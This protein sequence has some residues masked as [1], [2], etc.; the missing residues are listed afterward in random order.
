M[1]VS[2]N[3]FLIRFLIS[4]K[5]HAAKKSQLISGR[6]YR[7]RL[8]FPNGESSIVKPPPKY[9]KMENLCGGRSHK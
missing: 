7:N 1:Y 5:I 3:S 4:A 8:L 9:Y 2:P 6:F